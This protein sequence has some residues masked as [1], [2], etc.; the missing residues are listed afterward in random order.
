ML[1]TTN[2]TFW[3]IKTTHASKISVVNY[4]G[5][6]DFCWKQRC[7]PLGQLATLDE[8]KTIRAS[9]LLSNIFPVDGKNAIGR[10]GARRYVYT[11]LTLR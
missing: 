10:A 7:G 6:A 2:K 11:G 5:M 8:L 4:A 9:T 1:A 3:S